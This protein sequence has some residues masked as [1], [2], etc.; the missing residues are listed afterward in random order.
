MKALH[1]LEEIARPSDSFLFYQDVEKEIEQA[2][3]VKLEGFTAMKTRLIHDSVKKW[4]KIAKGGVKL[5]VRWIKTGGNNNR[6]MIERVEKR[7]HE[8]L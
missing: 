3:V 4:A 6:E 7:Q 5:I 1:N 2:T 8:H